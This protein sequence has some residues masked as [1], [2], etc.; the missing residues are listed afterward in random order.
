MEYNSKDAFQTKKLDMFNTEIL[1]LLWNE[2]YTELL[3]D[4][5]DSFF[6]LKIAS[7]HSNPE[8]MVRMLIDMVDFC[9]FLF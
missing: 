8:W 6:R 5:D 9:F 3:E 1:W 4:K 2:K 7:I